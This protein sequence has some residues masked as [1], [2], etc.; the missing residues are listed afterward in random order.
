M[1][2]GKPWTDEEEKQ[3]RE[4]A[5]QKKS[6]RVIARTMGKSRDCVRQ[7]LWRLGLEVVGHS[8]N[9]TSPTTSSL[10]L[11][12]DLP[13]IEYALKLLAATMEQL[14]DTTLDKTAVLRLRTLFQASNLYQARVAEFINYREIELKIIDLEE[15][16]ERLLNE[17]TKDLDAKNHSTSSSTI[18]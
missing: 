12:E 1:V 14:R 8:E 3:L 11:P 7:K 13:S 17:K 10:K 2:K 9:S 5:A 4:L 16:Y 15:K 18:N 6:A